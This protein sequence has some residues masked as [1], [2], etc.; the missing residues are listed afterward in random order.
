[1]QNFHF[2][3]VYSS[4]SG[5]KVL[6]LL[7][8]NE[9]KISA[10]QCSIHYSHTGDGDVLDIVAHKNVPLSEVIASDILDSDHPLNIFHKFRNWERFQR[11]ASEIISPKIQFN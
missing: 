7:L 6:N 9:F 8:I 11:L 10:P 3:P 1:M 5:V 4:S 2:G